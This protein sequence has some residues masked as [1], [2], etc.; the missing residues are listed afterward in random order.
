MINV[1]LFDLDDTLIDTRIYAEL[2]KPILQLIENKTGL[3]DDELNNK[4]KQLGLKQ[5]KYERW[6]TGDLCRELGL[7]DEYYE[8]LKKLIAIVP[9]LHDT[10]EKVFQELKNRGKRIGIVSNSMQRTIQT[11]V[12]KYQLTDYV[13]FIFSQDDVGCRKDNDNY[14]KKLIE[15]EKLNPTECLIIGDDEIEDIEIPQ[16]FAFKVYHLKDSSD[17]KEVLNQCPTTT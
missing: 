3:K 10:V 2:Y 9:I 14:W 5:N 11:Y 1:Y 6:D 17:L 15:R 13:D 12:S 16:K 8:E 7:L 4:A